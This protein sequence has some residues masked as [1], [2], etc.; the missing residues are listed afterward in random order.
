M[1][2]W[3]KPLVS[4]AQVQLVAGYAVFDV[5]GGGAPDEDRDDLAMLGDELAKA[6]ARLTSG[7]EEMLFVEHGVGDLPIRGGLGEM[8]FQRPANRRIRAELGIEIRNHDSNAAFS[9]S[10]VYGDLELPGI[11]RWRRSN[12]KPYEDGPSGEEVLDF[13]TIGWKRNFSR[14]AIQSQIS[15]RSASGACV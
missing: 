5:P 12:Q 6:V 11:K 14:Q 10:F 3:E 1:W 8:D 15:A 9:G 4:P 7:T 13:H 2:S